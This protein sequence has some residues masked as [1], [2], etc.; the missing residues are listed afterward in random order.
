MTPTRPPLPR[1]HPVWGLNL[2]L[3]CVTAAVCAWVLVPGH[4]ALATPGLPW[5]LLAL[6]VAAT[7]RWPVKLEFRRSAHSFSMTDI[8]LVLALV[9]ATP[10]GMLAGVAVGT[11]A[12]MALRRLG[13]IKFVFNLLQFVLSAAVG[14]V[15]V[16]AFVAS[17]GQ[18][19]GPTAW[20]GVA[21]GLQFG[22]LVTF[23]LVCAAMF[24]SEGAISREQLRQMFS[25]DALVTLTNTSL[26][27][28]LVAIS[29][30]RG[31]SSVPRPSRSS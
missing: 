18:G 9:F 28:L 22:G 14:M 12:A 13:P 6:F 2:V 17:S 5:W 15:I 29:A 23:I 19:F 8:P 24:L 1:V 16:R 31:T 27:L 4:H 21:V 25:V 10:A 30:K 3:G 26:A 11:G 7:E 20:L